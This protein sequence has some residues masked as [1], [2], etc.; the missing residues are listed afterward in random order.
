MA[1]LAAHCEPE[2]LAPAPSADSNA[3]AAGSSGCLD[4]DGDGFG[5][6]CARGFDCDDHDPTVATDCGALMQ[7]QPCEG[8][9][10]RAC[11]L[12]D[13][14]SDSAYTC[15]QGTQQCE[16][17][18][19]SH[20]ATTTEFQVNS[21]LSALI[22]GPI[23]CNPCD[24]ACFASRN[25]P[26]AAELTTSNSENLAFDPITGG[27]SLVEVEG[28][29][30][31]P[32][33]SD[34]DGVPDKYEPAGCVYDPS[35]DGYTEN[36]GLFHMLPY[37]GPTRVS[38][39]DVD[40]RLNT[41]DVYFLMDTTQSMQGSIDALRTSLIS[42]NFLLNPERCGLPANVRHN[43]GHPAPAGYEG[44]LGAIRC[45][46]PNIAFGVGSFDDY[47]FSG[48][49]DAACHVDG[50]DD[51]PFTHWL[52]TTVPD[53]SNLQNIRN[54]I[55]NY[56]ARC[57]GSVPE[58]QVPALYSIATGEAIHRTESS[59]HFSVPPHEDLGS[60]GVGGVG[61]TLENPYPLGD[62]TDNLRYVRYDFRNLTN[63]YHNHC[64][65]GG[66]S[67]NGKDAVFSFTL[68]KRQQVFITTHNRVNTDNQF[69][70]YNPSGEYMYCHNGDGDRANIIQVLNPGTYTLMV[71]TRSM[72]DDRYSDLL[73]GTWQP[74]TTPFTPAN[75]CPDGRIG[76]PCFRQGSIPIVMLFTDAP[77][78]NFDSTGNRYWMPAPTFNNAVYALNER[79][80]KVI[81]IN[82][83]SDS[84]HRHC[85]TPCILEEVTSCT[86]ENYQ[87]CLSGY[88]CNCNT[89]YRD[90]QT[91]TEAYSCCGWCCSAEETRQRE[92]CSTSCTVYGN[93]VCEFSSSTAGGNL[94]QVAHATGTVDD[95]GLPLVYQVSADGSGLSEAVVKSVS[96]LA[97]ST[98]MDI[99]MRV[100]DNPATPGVNEAGF[101]TS[102]AT[103]PTPE[104]DARCDAVF[105]TYFRRCRPDTEVRFGVS[106]HNHFV[107]PTTE[108]QIFTFD[109][110]VVGD[111]AFVL[112]TIPVTIVVPGIG[113]AFANEGRYWRDYNAEAECGDASQRTLL[114][115][116][117]EASWDTDIS[118]A[119]TDVRFE[120]RLAES[121]AGLDSA[122]PMTWLASS[123]ASPLA[124][125]PLAESFGQ[126]PEATHARLTA[127]LQSSPGGQ[128]AP[129][130][131]EMELRFRCEA[132][133]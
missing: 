127:V 7:R 113:P 89:C 14:F 34:G 96:D 18:L 107:A 21:P 119:G 9:G 91:G 54:A 28:G 78:H 83:G 52:D 35:C 12:F 87:H 42:G 64:R 46:I 22:T 130:F 123:A 66:G 101:V 40:V 60:I 104:T 125:G 105:P 51:V 50:R 124:V 75:A 72:S 10:T 128:R 122:A 30:G 74:I 79:D 67:T 133:D 4:R 19:W 3:A 44:L 49:G 132:R 55:G 58:S 99:S 129:T 13:S 43:T 106:F 48:Y 121:V 45:E 6:G 70:L 5:A 63:K 16:G 32:I 1:M 82:S 109:L 120:L 86:T 2:E 31:E 33:D 110:E 65:H 131:Y 47:P 77:M 27:V 93:E 112:Q 118:E 98:A 11:F 56:V 36:G 59:A 53:G 111:G 26:T 23:A 37:E 94:K 69:I 29:T 85:H 95:A 39:L 100:V 15:K 68:T 57:G 88:S 61:D 38:S 116:W 24:P 81:G 80:M 92:T 84:T 90:T 115:V 20:C 17:G 108:D 25:R 76:Y 62:I 8:N 126:A 71:N 114:P 97:G 102:I 41:A 73:I 117:R 103:V